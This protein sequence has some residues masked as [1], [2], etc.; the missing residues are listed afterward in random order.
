MGTVDNSV[1]VSFPQMGQWSGSPSGVRDEIT[2]R[3][4]MLRTKVI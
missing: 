3:D 4:L 2:M 1:R